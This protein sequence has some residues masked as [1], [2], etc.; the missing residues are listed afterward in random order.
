MFVNAKKILKLK[1]FPFFLT[2]HTGPSDVSSN[3][4]S[5]CMTDPVFSDFS[6]SALIV[7]WV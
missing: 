4:I 2:F 7:V 3:G 5:F 1:S 6:I